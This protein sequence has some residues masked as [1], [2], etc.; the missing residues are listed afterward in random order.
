MVHKYVFHYFPLRGRGEIIRYL[1]A[2]ADQHYDE[3]T[4]TMEE[5]PK[6]KSGT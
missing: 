5:W 3:K 2:Y 1:F 4:Y 6:H